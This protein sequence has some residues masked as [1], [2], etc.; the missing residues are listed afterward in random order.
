MQIVCVNWKTAGRSLRM[1]RQLHQPLIVPI[2]KPFNLLLVVLLLIPDAVD[3]YLPACLDFN[4]RMEI[5]QNSPQVLASSAFTGP[6]PSA[7]PWVLFL[8]AVYSLSLTAVP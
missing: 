3:R 4:Y 2:N 6:S 7:P 5:V 8:L 1:K